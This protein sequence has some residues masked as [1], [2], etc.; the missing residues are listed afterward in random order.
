M[1][2]KDLENCQHR[3]CQGIYSGNTGL[4]LCRDA[5]YSGIDDYLDALGN[6]VPEDYPDNPF[7]PNEELRPGSGLYHHG[8]R[9]GFL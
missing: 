5:E 3:G 9:F 7:Y 2:K 1:G 8:R 6:S 4:F